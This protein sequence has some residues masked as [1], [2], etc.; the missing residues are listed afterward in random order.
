MSRAMSLKETRVSAAALRT[1]THARKRRCT[2]EPHGDPVGGQHISGTVA[3]RLSRR[4]ATG[5]MGAIYEAEQLGA[6]G[7]VKRVAIKTI[8]RKR[9][10]DPEFVRMFIREA[11]LAA[12]LVH[13][14]IVQIYQFGRWKQGFFIAMEYIDGVDLA[15]FIATHSYLKRLPPV[16][17]STFIVSRVCRALEYAHN[18]RDEHGLRLGIVHRDVAPKNILIT[19]EGEVKLGDFGV[20]KVRRDGG[21]GEGVVLVGSLGYMSPEQASYKPVDHRSDVFSLGIVYYQLLTGIQPFGARTESAILQRVAKS[22]IRRPGALRRAIPKDVERIVMR[23]L[24]RDPADR[25]QTAGALGYALEQNMYSKGYGPTIV[26]LA[27]YMASLYPD[28][29]FYAPPVSHD[30]RTETSRYTRA[31]G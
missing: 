16:D 12:A 19:N 11:K 31:G 5:G 28:R 25:Y 9:I 15:T 1:T 2:R 23:C 14:N 6:E 24:A 8:R 21:Q 7:F 17:I 30:A 3:Y 22:K 20:A 4:I 10:K 27:N 18:K 26:M 13:Q 29:R